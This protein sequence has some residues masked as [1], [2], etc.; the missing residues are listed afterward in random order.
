MLYVP[1][2]YTYYPYIHIYIIIW[3]IFAFYVNIALPQE[4]S[5]ISLSSYVSSFFF[6]E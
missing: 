5:A 6:Y 2:M 3:G 1:N 4:F